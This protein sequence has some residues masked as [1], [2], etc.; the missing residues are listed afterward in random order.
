MNLF[1][2]LAVRMGGK[3]QTLFQDKTAHFIMASLMFIAGLMSSTTVY[4][5]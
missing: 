3:E 2:A 5:M 4:A 1:S